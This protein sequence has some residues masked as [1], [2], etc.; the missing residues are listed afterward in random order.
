MKLKKILDRN[1]P[2]LQRLTLKQ[3]I[4]HRTFWHIFV[5]LMCSMSFSYFL[6]PQLKNYGSNKFNDDAFLTVIGIVAFATSAISKFA[7]GIAQDHLG[8]IKVYMIMIVIQLFTTA[9]LA[10]VNS[11]SKVVFTF[12]MIFAFICEGAHFVIFPAAA[13]ALYGPK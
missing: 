12:L 1:K 3:A 7:W 5:M 6:K 4:F 13:T 11:S 2:P 10:F 8:F 9:T